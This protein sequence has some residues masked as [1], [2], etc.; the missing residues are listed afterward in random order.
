MGRGIV[1]LVF[2]GETVKKIAS[3]SEHADC[4]WGLLLGTTPR[5]G[6]DCFWPVT[7]F[8]KPYKNKV[9][10]ISDVKDHIR[11]TDS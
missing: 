2:S 10:L 9:F 4:P 5:E 7:D 8:I 1:K 3:P 11:N 6:D